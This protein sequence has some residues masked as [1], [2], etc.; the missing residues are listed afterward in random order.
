MTCQCLAAKRTTR[1]TV[2]RRPFL[3]L[4]I[5]CSHTR[6]GEECLV[7]V[8]IVWLYAPGE[9]LMQRHQQDQHMNERKFSR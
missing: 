6:S 1:S 5:Y 3:F 4:D 7:G 8:Y 9:I 2:L